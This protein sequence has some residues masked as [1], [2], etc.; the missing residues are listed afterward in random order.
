MRP[1]SSAFVLVDEAAQ[2]VAPSHA[3]PSGTKTQSSRRCSVLVDES[4]QYRASP[5]R[6]LVSCFQVWPV[7]PISRRMESH[8]SVA[9][10]VVVISDVVR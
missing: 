4:A 6:T 1:S 8:R 10:V 5:D 9:P 3:D 7:S 2:H